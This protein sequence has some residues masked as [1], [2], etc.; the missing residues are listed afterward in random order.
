MFILVFVFSLLGI[1]C[2]DKFN[3]SSLLAL[4]FIGLLG[5][6]YKDFSRKN[7]F[8]I[9]LALVF[10]IN[11]ISLN[12][13]NSIILDE[14]VTIIGTIVEDSL[15][16][17]RRYVLRDKFFNRYLIYSEEPLNLGDKVKIEGKS[18]KPLGKMNDFD[19]NYRGYLKSKGINYIIYVNKVDFLGKSYLNNLKSGFRDY[20]KASLRP[21]S[22]DNKKIILAVLLADSDY[23]DDGR[24]LDF[25]QAG[26]SH[27]LAMSGLHIGL[28]LLISEKLLE[29]L[30]FSKIKR[31]LFS[32]FIAFSY[33]YLV[34]MPLGALR[35]YLMYLFLFLSFIFKKKYRSIDAL[36]LSGTLTLLINPYAFYSLSFLLSYL[37]VLGIILFYRRFNILF[38]RRKFSSSLALTSSVS[39]MILPACLYYFNEFSILGFISNLIV[40]PFYT[41]AI[42][43]SYLMVIFNF[44][45]FI[46][47]P[48][49]NLALDLSNFIL[50][51][52]NKLNFINLN[53]FTLS[54]ASLVVYYSAIAL[55]LVREK[56]KGYYKFNKAVFVS[57]VGVFILSFSIYYYNY[58]RSYEMDFLYVAQ[59][60][61][62][63][64]RD[65]NSYTMV[66]LAGSFNRDYRSGEI[67]TL[68]ALRSKGIKKID[69]LF[70]SHFDL[71]HSDGLFDIIDYV[72]IK[73][74]YLPYYEDNEYVDLL[75][76]KADKVYLLK[77]GD[78]FK[79][80]DLNIKVI[81]ASL[82]KFKSNDKSMVFL[83]DYKGFKSL[84][85][86]DIS[87]DREKFIN[88]NADLLKVPHHGSNTSGSQEFLERVN[89][90]FATISAGL[91]NIYNHPGNELIDRL[92]AQGI[93]W[94]ST[95]FNGGIKLKITGDRIT[96]KGYLDK[97][98]LDLTFLIAWI[99]LLIFIIKYGEYFAVQ[100]NLQKRN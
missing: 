44:A 75:K 89:P 16:N 33:I 12:F 17:N 36:A 34:F 8:L 96:F 5:F 85:T 30:K 7:R 9:V 91:D 47:A 53:L 65:G 58:C 87:E 22:E 40:L 77:T 60:E 39:L 74:V 49:V 83:T 6:L 97:E 99:I 42:V 18:K 2:A 28:I 55:Y 93:I 54:P 32:L 20:V 57:M 11:V 64:I 25:R 100:G 86:G 24:K 21:L 1:I 29:L 27:I 72:K 51:F 95:N 3:I 52:I 13:K 94:K 56:F 68:K 81:S 82:E 62:T 37:S 19:F 80:K 4:A 90:K 66:D 35:A 23:I 84:F 45:S 88:V 50:S 98:P 15:K 69:N 48:S 71:D 43:L 41:F 92:N 31:R 67:Y 70:I 59:G 79:L 38:K 14:N 78:R 61:S 73:N 63:L 76:K 26:L 10:L 46:L